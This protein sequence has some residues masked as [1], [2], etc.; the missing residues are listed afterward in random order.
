MTEI[1][2]KQ[3][4][5]DIKRDDLTTTLLLTL[6]EAKLLK[7]QLDSLFG[8]SNDAI[9]YNPGYKI[10]TIPCGGAYPYAPGCGPGNGTADGVGVFKTTTTDASSISVRTEI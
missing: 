4:V 1:N 8:Q 2:I 5:I 9:T 3:I 6:D 7:R 10:T